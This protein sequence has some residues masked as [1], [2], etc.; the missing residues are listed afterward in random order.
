[1]NLNFLILSICKQPGHVSI[2][3]LS[4]FYLGYFNILSLD[5]ILQF[6]HYS[7]YIFQL[8]LTLP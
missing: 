5:F 2:L 1:M 3:A 6:S 8:N 7:F 4:L